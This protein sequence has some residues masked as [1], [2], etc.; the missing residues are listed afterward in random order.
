MFH[1]LFDMCKRAIAL[2]LMEIEQRKNDNFAHTTNKHNLDYFIEHVNV[3]AGSL[4]HLSYF[5]D[6]LFFDIFFSV[7]CSLSLSLL[8]CFL[9]LSP[10]VPL[11]PCLS[12]SLQSFFSLRSNFALNARKGQIIESRLLRY[13]WSLIDSIVIAVVVR[14]II[15]LCTRKKNGME[16]P[17]WKVCHPFDQPN[18]RWRTLTS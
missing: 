16:N 7:S 10:S 17:S 2:L 3:F 4:S 15:K 11:S 14:I 5:W 1:R 9:S 6:W 18:L 12:I 13:V 8:L